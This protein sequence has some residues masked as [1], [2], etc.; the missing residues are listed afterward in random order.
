MNIHG[1]F[2]FLGAQVDHRV[3]KRGFADQPGIFS[4]QYGTPGIG[5]DLELEEVSSEYLGAGWVMEPGHG[6]LSACAWL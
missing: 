1:I 3:Q 5:S 4:V 6:A 2:A